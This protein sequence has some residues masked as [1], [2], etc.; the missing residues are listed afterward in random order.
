MSTD[1]DGDF[2]TV[3]QPTE[4]S[5]TEDPMLFKGGFNHTGRREIIL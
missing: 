5:G 4:T 2:E 3:F 1:D